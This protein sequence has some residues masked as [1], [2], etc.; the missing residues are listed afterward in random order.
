MPPL[1]LASNGTFKETPDRGLSGR[2]RGLALDNSTTCC[3]SVC[4]FY[5][6]CSMWPVVCIVLFKLRV[7]MCYGLLCVYMFYVL[8]FIWF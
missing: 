4:L 7:L 6:S 8:L 5:G 3:V 1:L 2:L